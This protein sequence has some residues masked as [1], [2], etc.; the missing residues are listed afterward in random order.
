MNIVFFKPTASAG[1]IKCTIHRN[2]KLGFSKAA[3]DKLGITL[4]KYAKLGFDEEDKTDNSFYLV[5]Q[6]SPDDE[7]FKINK[8]G[9]Y[10]YLNT[11]NLFDEL[12]LDYLRKK[13]IYDIQE[14]KNDYSDLYKLKKRE[15]IREKS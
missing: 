1:K 13:I 15:I 11:K 4:G 10:Y 7:T 14:I 8:A 12:N 3:I 9:A 5:I 2:G 6:E